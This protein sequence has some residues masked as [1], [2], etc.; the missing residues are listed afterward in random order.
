[1][2]LLLGGPALALAAQCPDVKLAPLSLPHV[3]AALKNRQEV[4]IVAIGS[5]STA[6]SRAS[7]MAH[8]YPAVLQVELERG[9][10]GAHIAV[11][12]R[13]VG[14]QDAAEM[15][16]RLENDALAAAPTMVIWQLGANAS[17]RNIDLTQFSTLVT[18]GVQRLE[19]AGADVVLMDNQR[20]PAV[21][22]S[23]THAKIDQVLADIAGR[24][25]ARLFARGRLMDLW[26]EAGHPYNE[27]IDGDGIHHNDLGYACLA[28][29]LA[30][31]IL[32]GLSPDAVRLHA[33]Q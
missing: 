1:M 14:G 31:S 11:L 32:S 23:P 13:G 33:A 15:V 8:T 7:D 2:A 28:K 19:A 18:T 25:H 20:S 22:A 17:M 24:E 27:F 21:L 4:L 16:P 29:A 30:G 6:G 12:N 9:L 5:S 3:S 26:Q 10:P